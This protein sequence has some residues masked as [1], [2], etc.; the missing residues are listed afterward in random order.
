MR[1]AVLGSMVF[2]ALLVGCSDRQRP[3]EQ[4]GSRSTATT[5][6]GAVRIVADPDD[7]VLSGPGLAARGRSC[8]TRIESGRYS[9]SSLAAVTRVDCARTVRTFT[10][11]LEQ[12]VRRSGAG[13]DCYPAFCTLDGFMIT[14]G[15]RCTAMGL[16]DGLARVTCRRGRSIIDAAALVS[17]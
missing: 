7:A 12:V 13:E 6:A 8:R 5:T 9:Y 1:R 10:A 4:D 3:A 11:L 15:F 2:G 14:R 16:G 17:E